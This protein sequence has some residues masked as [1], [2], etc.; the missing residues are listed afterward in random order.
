MQ[1]EDD[2]VKQNRMLTQQVQALVTE[3]Q[4]LKCEK[5]RL[6]E[7]LL[8]YRS[9]VEIANGTIATI[10]AEGK[11]KFVTP[12]WPAL[13][14]YDPTDPSFQFSFKEAVHPDDFNS[15]MD[16]VRRTFSTGKRQSD[17]EYRVRYKDGTWRWLTAN[18]SPVFDKDGKVTTVLAIAWDVTEQKETGFKLQRL[19][20]RYRLL[21]DTMREGVVIVDND[22]IVQFVNKSCCELFGLSAEDII[23]KPG[24]EVIIHEE[25]RHQI[26][27]K[28]I[29]RTQGVAD[30]Y[31]LRGKK[32]NGDIIWLR[33]SGA[34]LRD[35]DGKV[36]GSVGVMTDV[37]E[38][39]TLREKLLAS[40]KLEA[41]GKLAG[42][43]AH[44]FNNLLNIIQGYSEELNDELPLDSPL[45]IGVAE[46]LKAGERAAGLTRQLLTFSRMQIVKPR[47]LDVNELLGNFSNLLHRLMGEKIQIITTLA[48]KLL[49]VKIDPS[50]LELIIENLAVNAQEAMPQGGVLSIETSSLRVDKDS[51]P[52]RPDI[53]PGQ[54]VQFSLSDT[55]CGMDE[56]TVS[57]IFE[58]FFTTKGIGSGVGLGLSTVYGIV[59]QAGGYII[60]KSELGKG[61]NVTVLLPE[62]TEM[63]GRTSPQSHELYIL[64]KGEHILIVEDE[65]ALLSYFAKLIKNLGYKVSACSESTEALNLV[66]QGLKP[67]L[68]IT[69][70][71]MP[72]MNGKQ[73]ADKVL[74]LV[75][76]Q[77]VLFM[78]GFTND[79][80]VQYEVFEQGMPFIQKPFNSR[81]IAVQIRS[82]LNGA[83]SPK[84][85]ANIFMLDDEEGIRRLF[86]RS[87]IKRGHSFKGVGLLPDALKVLA[88]KQFDV[89]LIDMHL[90]GMDG[91]HALKIIREAGIS[92]PAIF[93]TGAIHIEDREAL[94]PLGVIKTV[95]KSFD[96]E[97]VLKYIEGL[98]SG[99]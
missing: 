46:V 37:T 54:Y 71:I 43:I 10:D 60:L 69:D 80:I 50:Q 65:K 88:E 81:D 19:Y 38:S 49:H 4:D 61:T 22:D 72:M 21:F 77:K 45:R 9:Y 96:N 53:K 85:S 58:P 14:G 44:D 16:I 26:I 86:E 64:G 63:L 5:D 1:I 39:K 99:C 92:T 42:G 51:M 3:L 13:L 23:G 2:L 67:D 98:I 56:A 89:M 31:E 47:V 62:S 20:N 78:S 25:D 27:E 30:E 73:L 76:E 24:N 34:P 36:I 18:T 28:N 17:L 87:C 11:F 95:E 84:S 35:E 79:A 66:R 52:N 32:A 8:Q 6:A 29:A 70:V 41:I 33:I 59:T 55:G 90:V 91:V 83:K 94:K 68:M 40:Q 57:K 97:P 15:C 74:E 75:P 12:N 48:D 93:F 7:K 82:L